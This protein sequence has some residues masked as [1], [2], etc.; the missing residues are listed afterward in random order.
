M[1]MLEYEICLARSGRDKKIGK[2]EHYSVL[3]KSVDGGQGKI[4]NG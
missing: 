2:R 3:K 1:K 4:C